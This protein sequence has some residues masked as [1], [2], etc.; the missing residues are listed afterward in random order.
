MVVSQLLGSTIA[1][2]SAHVPSPH[3]LASAGKGPSPSSPKQWKS[4]GHVNIY[5]FVSARSPLMKSKKKNYREGRNINSARVSALT[6]SVPR[7]MA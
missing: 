4:D 6:G 3:I 5:N 2:I 1:I 7:K